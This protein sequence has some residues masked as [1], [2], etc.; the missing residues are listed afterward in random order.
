[1]PLLLTPWPAEA[2]SAVFEEEVGYLGVR[3]ERVA[4]PA[5]ESLATDLRSAD[6]QVRLKALL[7]LGL[8]EGQTHHA[9]WGPGLA[10]EGDWPEGRND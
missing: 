5:P 4:W 6:S 3:R 8:A 7:L 1:M 2:H 9:V 10:D